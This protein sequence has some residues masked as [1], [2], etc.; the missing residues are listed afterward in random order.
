MAEQPNDASQKSKAEGDRWSPESEAA[1]PDER[2]GYRTDEEGSGV[3]NRT[4]DEEIE[5][6][7]SLPARGESKPGAH[8]G[9]GDSNPDKDRSER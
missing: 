5:N 8:A 2:S 7:E 9:H 4:L 3:T 6:Q 1:G